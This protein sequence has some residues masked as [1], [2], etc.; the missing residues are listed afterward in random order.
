MIWRDQKQ[1]FGNTL[2]NRPQSLLL[3]RILFQVH[4]W[5]G[6][7][8]GLYVLVVGVT[9]ASLVF[10]EEMQHAIYPEFFP[11]TEP[12]G[13]VANIVDVVA[14]MKAPYPDSQLVGVGVPNPEQHTFVGY[15]YK[16]EKYRAVFADVSTGKI[17]G[18]FPVQS[19]ILWLQNLHFYLLAGDTGLFVNGLGSLFLVG[20]CITGFVIWWPGVGNWRRNLKIDFRANWK[21]LNWDLHNAIGLWTLAFVFMWGVTGAYF[22]FPQ[23]F[24]TIVRTFSAVTINRSVSSRPPTDPNAK[25][26]DLRMLVNKAQQAL[27]N[28]IVTRVSLPSSKQGP[29][30]VVLTKTTPQVRE[31]A[32][33]VY[34]FFDQFTGDLIEQRNL[35]ASTAGDEAISWLGRLHTGSFGGITIKILWL[36]FGLVPALLF[37]TGSI[38]WWNRV[39]SPRMREAMKPAAALERETAR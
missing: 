37:I 1:M 29:V 2:Y 7:G 10:R 6:I 17:I 11:R 5:V 26:A 13:P 28:G 4:L 24:R 23:Q 27:P 15:L 9:G 32:D 30:Q 12:A 21:R 38:M 19:F 3:R 35:A 36:I 14:N 34:F 18:A 33:Y 16:D 39:V 8:A 31:N 20:L 25:T 22:A